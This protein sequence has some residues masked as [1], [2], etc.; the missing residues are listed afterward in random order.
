MTGVWVTIAASTD[1]HI[2]CESA[3]TTVGP[4]PW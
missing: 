3:N 1:S 2:H 4:T